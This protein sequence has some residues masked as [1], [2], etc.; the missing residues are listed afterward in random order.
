MQGRW[1]RMRAAPVVVPQPKQPAPAC[2]RQRQPALRAVRAVAQAL[3]RVP[4]CLPR[5]G[6]AV[7]GV[8]QPRGPG[9]RRAVGPA[10]HPGGLV[11][12][13]RG[14]AAPRAGRRL[15][16]RRRGGQRDRAPGGRRRAAPERCRGRAH[17]APFGRAGAVLP[18]RTGHALRAFYLGVPGRGASGLGPALPAGSGQPVH[19]DLLVGCD[20]YHSR[21]WEDLLGG[22]G[23][24]F[25]GAR[26]LPG[27]HLSVCS[28]PGPP[29]RGAP[30]AE[31]LPSLSL[32]PLSLPPPLPLRP[33]RLA[34]RRPFREPPDSLPT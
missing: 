29:E 10:A 12:A 11:G 33:A 34:A 19:A 18:W 3:A 32:S 24:D 28:R 6:T 2:R 14:T 21:V 30:P 7:C 4:P 16:D 23:P 27:R 13:G 15:A 17:G 5:G 22:K 31:A 20:G 9:R 8:P 26:F 25:A 1:G